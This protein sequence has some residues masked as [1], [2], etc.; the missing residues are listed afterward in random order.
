ME[1]IP[2]PCVIYMTTKP[3]IVMTKKFKEA[4]ALWKEEKRQSV[5]LSSYAL[6]STILNTHLLPAFG[7][8]RRIT[9]GQLKSFAAE[10]SE[11][12]LR[13][14]T[15]RIIFLVLKMITRFAE[16]RCG[17]SHTDFD[18]CIPTAVESA[19][20][21]QRLEVLTPAQERRLLEYL[22]G[23]YSFAG[24]GILIGLLTG[25]R[26]GEVC[27]LTWADVDLQRRMLHVERTVQRLWLI[28]GDR[29]QCDIITGPP[30]TASSRREVPLTSDLLRLLRPLKKQFP[31]DV[32]VLSA[33][34]RPMEPRTLRTYYYQILR[35]LGLPPVRF[36][37]LRHTFATRCVESRCD[38]KTLSAILGHSAIGT[39]MNLYVHPDET[40]KRRCVEQMAR[41]LRMRAK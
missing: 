2:S 37:G 31:A 30:K 10:L 13:P 7:E 25:M 28:D 32:F 27:G 8:C 34:L 36:H 21:R 41:S 15:I 35:K 3:M 11:R 6:Y 12:Q 9:E 24:L 40:A 1:R 26:I 38:Y 14:S 39:T 16:K 4:T 29:R 20:L 19:P 23:H 17:W 5:K 33:Q 22:Y 18:R